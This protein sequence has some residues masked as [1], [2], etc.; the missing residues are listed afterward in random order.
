VLLGADYEPQI[1]IDD[2]ISDLFFFVGWN[3]T[4]KLNAM[5]YDKV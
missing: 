5:I 1:D 3:T 2:P 4:A